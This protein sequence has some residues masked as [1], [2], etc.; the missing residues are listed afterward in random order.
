VVFAPCRC[1][2]DPLRLRFRV[3]RKRSCPAAS[4]QEQGSEGDSSE[5]NSSVV[6]EQQPVQAAAVPA[7]TSYGGA[8]T[9]S[10]PLDSTDEISMAVL[11]TGRCAFQRGTTGRPKM[12]TLV[13]C[14]A[15]ALSG[16]WNGLAVPSP[17]A[18]F[19]ALF[20]VAHAP[21]HLAR[22]VDVFLTGTCRPADPDDSVALPE[23]FCIIES[24][25]SVKVRP[26]AARVAT[27]ELLTNAGQV[28]R[29]SVGPALPHDRRLSGSG[30]WGGSCQLGD[31]HLCS[32]KSGVAVWQES[33]VNL[34]SN[35]GK[36]AAG[37]WK[38]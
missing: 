31:S 13:S 17:G 10:S 14:A 6:L 11:A 30:R 25:D 20:P 5:G 33:I 21:A 19:C 8:T 18:A 36:N 38:E 23:N 32:L 4:Q 1:R 22:T 24:R 37:A 12:T 2:F 29:K 26:S 7:S 34:G 3:R 16:A 9:A 15:R 35:C 28:R 27:P